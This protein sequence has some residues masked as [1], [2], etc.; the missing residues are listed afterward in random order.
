MRPCCGA[1]PSAPTQP[2][3]P[4]HRARP[5]AELAALLRRDVSDL[6]LSFFLLARLLVD[7]L[8]ELLQLRLEQAN[9]IG[10]IVRPGGAMEDD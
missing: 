8:F 6:N 1:P 7:L 10:R 9:F 4:L 3:G 2:R 5:A